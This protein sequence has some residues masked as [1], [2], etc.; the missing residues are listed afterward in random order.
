MGNIKEVCSEIVKYSLDKLN[1][2]SED[3]HDLIMATGQAESG[4]D[5]LKQIKGPAIGFWQMGPAT[6]F[7]IW[8]NYVTYRVKY[9]DSLIQ[10]SF[11]EGDAVNSLLTNLAVQAAFCRLHYRRVP[12]KLPKAGDLKGQAEYWK[13]YYNTEKG[14]GT[15]EHFIKKNGG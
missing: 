6:L 7:D 15:I 11:N 1:L 10:L 9:K 8:E 5:Y 4:Y 2:Y 13:K 14:K 12:A 3:A